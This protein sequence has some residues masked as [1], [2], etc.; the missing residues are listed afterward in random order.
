[1]IA[2]LSTLSSGAISA[3]FLENMIQLRSPGHRMAVGIVITMTAAM[4]QPE[5]ER[6][7]QK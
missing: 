6:I 7:D 5:N 2:I 1:M 3:N 4:G